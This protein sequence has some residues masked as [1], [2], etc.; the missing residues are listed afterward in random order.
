MVKPRLFSFIWS[1]RMI[2]LLA[3]SH[4]SWSQDCK[5]YVDSVLV[6]QSQF[7]SL[8]HRNAETNKL[9]L[10][11]WKDNYLF[12][13]ISD[14]SSNEIYIHKGDKYPFVVGALDES[15][16]Q[17]INKMGKK[18]ISP[19]QHAEAQ[20]KY[21]SDHGYPFATFHL[22]GIQKSRDSYTADLMLSK[23]PFIDFD[24]LFLVHKIKTDEAYIEKTLD[25][26]RGTPFS[27]TSFQSIEKKIAR[28]PYLTLTQTPD[29]AFENESA[30][31]YLEFEERS[32]NSFE[33]V[34]GLLPGQSSGKALITGYLD[35]ELTNLFGSGKGFSFNWNRFAS[36]SQ[37]MEMEYSHPFFL[38]TRMLIDFG[39]SLLKQ[40]TSFVNQEWNLSLGTFLGQTGIIK[41]NYTS[42]NAN[43]ITTSQQ[44]I[45]SNNIVDYNR[46]I[47]SFSTELNNYDIPFG[48]KEGLKTY[49]SMAIGQ[50]RI[51]KNP[52]V[53]N[54]FYDSITLKS[55]L[56]KAAFKLKYQQ[57]IHKQL[58]VYHQ[59]ESGL[60]RNNQVLRNEMFRIGGL[61][62]MR[63][64][65]EN[66]FYADQYA[67]SRLEIRQYF[68]R[69]SY[70][71]IFYDQL[72]YQYES[73]EDFPLG[74]GLGLTLSANNS[75]FN[76]AMAV[77]KSRDIPFDLST[78][79]IHFGYI[80]RF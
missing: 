44:V 36:Q 61:R 18:S 48:F 1:L 69:E 55:N 71:M 32:S 19:F 77:G 54:Q 21:W 57:K 6:I 75:L 33:G 20:I 60:I 74:L 29:I 65:N 11:L 56:I 12:A 10:N 80:S 23:G 37:A 58:T 17:L 49:A 62:S 9:L 68:E 8:Y 4:Q 28:L 30:T 40:D 31:V 22:S 14:S 25:L 67:L 73:I 47:Y 39:F 45:S 78:A 35:L 79:K 38:D 41:A 64:F 7:K 42:S 34:V 63:G 50:K 27:E 53:D 46:D 13:Q 52:N 26:E 3:Y 76:F 51:R 72:Y 16:K 5:I 15:N 59:L 24:T 43:L 70:F 66:F 2:I